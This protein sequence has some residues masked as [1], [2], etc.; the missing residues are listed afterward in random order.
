LVQKTK[1]DYVLPKLSQCVSTTASFDLWMSK[2]AYYIFALVINFLDGNWKPNKVTIGL[3]ETTKTIGQTLARNLNELL[4][5]YN[6]R[7][8]II[9][10]VKDEGANLN[11]M[12]MALKIVINYDVLELE[13]SFNGTCFGCA[14]SKTCQHATIEK[15]ICKNLKF[16]LLNQWSLI[17]KNV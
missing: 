7:K 14:F 9:I 12:T 5:S 13:E 6:L 3:F 8:K 4:D 1:K 17:F 2:G 16:V 10:Y 15:K 11:A